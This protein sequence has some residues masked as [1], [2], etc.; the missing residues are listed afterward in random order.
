[1]G[2]F[3]KIAAFLRESRLETSKVNWPNREQTIKNTV[4]VILFTIAVA[5][6]LGLFDFLLGM[7]LDRFIL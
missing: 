7:G 5:S 1:M 6:I 3:S 4:V 2:F